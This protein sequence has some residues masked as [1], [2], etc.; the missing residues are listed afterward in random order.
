MQRLQAH[1]VEVIDTTGAGDTLEEAFMVAYLEGRA[2]V[3]RAQFAV[4]AAALACTGK[5]AV[6]PIPTRG[7]GDA[8][9]P[10]ASG[11]PPAH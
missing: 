1:S 4:A 9:L 7:Q 10:P 6:G 11:E 5:G 2:A 8:I 3:V